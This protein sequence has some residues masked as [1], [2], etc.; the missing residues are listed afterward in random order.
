MARENIHD[1]GRDTLHKS[2]LFDN[3][4][5]TLTGVDDNLK[6]TFIF[7]QS[8]WTKDKECTGVRSLVAGESKP[9]YFKLPG[10][11]GPFKPDGETPSDSHAIPHK[12]RETVL[13]LA[14]RF[15]DKSCILE[16]SSEYQSGLPGHN[17]TDA[18]TFW[19]NL[20]GADI[21]KQTY[22]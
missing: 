13:G 9:G 19:N 3:T 12:R 17:D 4:Y 11:G 18:Q 10:A 22:V 21:L 16:N 1:K 5:V 2:A 20:S 8:W 6:D 7:N 15:R 14:N